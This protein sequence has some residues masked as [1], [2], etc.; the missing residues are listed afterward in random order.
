MLDQ[1]GRG[2]PSD[3][4]DLPRLIASLVVAIRLGRVVVVPGLCLPRAHRVCVE[5]PVRD[6]DAADAIDQRPRLQLTG[7]EPLARVPAADLLAYLRFADLE[8]QQALRPDGCLD[9]RVVDQ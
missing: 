2:F 9:F 3:M 1:P 5:G 6:V 7:R 4:P 8:R